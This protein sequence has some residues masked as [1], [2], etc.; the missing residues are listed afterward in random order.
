MINFENRLFCRLDGLTA[1]LREQQRLEALA[2][3]NLLGS[4][5]IPVF[6]EATQTAAHFLAMPIAILGIMDQDCQRYKS[7]IGLSRLGVMNQLA[8]GRQ[9]PRVES[10]LQLCCGQ[11]AAAG[12][13]RH[14]VPS[15]LCQQSPYP[16]VW[17]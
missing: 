6:E 7:A 8:I 1:A 9:L 16:S 4:E 15:S 12:A 5:S 14:A 10:F 13:R 11:S 3:M 2:E 17:R